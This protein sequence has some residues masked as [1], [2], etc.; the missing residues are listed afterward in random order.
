[1]EKPVFNRELDTYF[2]NG[3]LMD[4][5]SGNISKLISSLKEVNLLPFGQGNIY[6]NSDIWDF[7]EYRN[8]NVGKHKRVFKFNNKMCPEIFKDTIKVYVLIKIVED[9][10]KIQ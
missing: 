3:V 2:D 10:L 1:M 5:K 7:S 9:K 8:T 4:L 6:F